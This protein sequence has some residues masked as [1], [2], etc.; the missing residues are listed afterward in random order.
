MS[1]ITNRWF[2]IQYYSIIDRPDTNEHVLEKDVTQKQVLVSGLVVFVVKS[3]EFLHNISLQLLQ[4]IV[5]IVKERQLPFIL[6]LKH[7]DTATASKSSKTATLMENLQ[8]YLGKT[9]TLIRTEPMTCKF[10]F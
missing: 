3:S 5:L 10:T 6:C 7:W 2:G 9:Y 1:R 4:Q 8:N